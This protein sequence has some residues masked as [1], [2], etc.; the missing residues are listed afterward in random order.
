MAD[1]N[2]T[3]TLEQTLGTNPSTSEILAS[4]LLFAFVAIVGWAVYFVFNRY[5]SKWAEKTETTLD[6]DIIAAVQSLIVV[7]VVIIGIEYAL[8]PLSFLQAY[9]ATLN[10]VF[11]VLE[12]FLCAFVIA[13]IVNIL[14]EFYLD[15][16]SRQ[17]VNKHHLVFM[18]KKIV[19]IVTYV[20][21]IIVILY[22][23]HFDLTGAV[24]GLGIGGI[25]IAF[26]LQSTLS[27]FFTSF[28]IYFD[29]P[30]EIGDFIVVGQN[31]GTVENITIRS[32][33]IKLLSGEELIVPNKELTAASVR[34]FRKLERRRIT[35][36]IGVTYDT[37]SEKLKKIPLIIRGIIENTENAEIERVHFTEFGDFALKFLVSYYVKVADYGVYL[38]IQ[39]SINFAIKDAFEREGI[40]M[41]LPTSTVYV[42]RKAPSA[43]LYEKALNTN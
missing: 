11:L 34:N 1:F 30:F 17:G 27:D 42:K 43:A 9:A 14:A 10:S 36:T 32:T 13:R 39:Q 33:R 20:A 29:R 25:A 23:S 21:A 26:A 3:S 31:S 22:I 41:A 40:E 2:L 24:V 35:F 16:T 4:I 37:S 5:F 28:F 6:D 19:Q 12:I 38:D 18:T 7:L 8:T 15:R